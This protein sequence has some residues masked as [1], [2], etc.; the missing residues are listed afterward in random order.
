LNP[1]RPRPRDP[2]HN[3]RRKRLNPEPTVTISIIITTRNRAAHLKA[4]LDAMRAVIVPDGLTA[5]LLVVDNGSTDDTGAVARAA[6]VGKIA[7]RTVHEP[8]PGQCRARNR[9]LAETSG[10]AVVFVDD[11]VRPRIDWL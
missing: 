9:G 7:V 11:D 4:T 1:S 6:R 10:D 8:E 3:D 2:E 5:E